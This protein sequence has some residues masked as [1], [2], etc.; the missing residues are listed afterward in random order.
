MSKMDKLLGHHRRYTRRELRSKLEQAG[1]CQIKIVNFNSLGVLGWYVNNT[2]RGNESLGTGQVKLF[3]A[4][5]P[6]VRIVDRVLP[7][8][9]LSVIGVGYKN[10]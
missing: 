1:L 7:L 5:V 10:H 2:L 9:G 6:I 3:D 8:P 4:L